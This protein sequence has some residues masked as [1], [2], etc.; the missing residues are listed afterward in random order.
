MEQQRPTPLLVELYLEQARI[1]GLNYQIEERRRLVDVLNMHEG[2]IQI[3]DA[4]LAMVGGQQR[5]MP[6]LSVEK[7]AV[8]AALPRETAEQTRHRLME[9]NVVGHSET[10]QLGLTLI[11]PPFVVEGTAHLLGGRQSV[12]KRLRADPDLFTR[13]FSVTDGKI[14]LPDGNTLEAPVIL[15]NRDHLVAVSEA[16]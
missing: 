12:R 14:Y 16:A 5:E 7:H 13:F 3:E 11:I 6:R 10:L 2:S 8:I 9:R 15:L 4:R 1:V